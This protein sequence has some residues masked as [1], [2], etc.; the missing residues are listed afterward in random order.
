MFGNI[1]N[2]LENEIAQIKENGLYKNERIIM[3]PQA[4]EIDVKNSAK[5][6]NFC[7]NNYLGLSSHPEVVQ[8]AKESFDQWGYGL[9]SVRF[10][11]GTQDIHKQLENKISNFLQMDDTILYTSCFDAN[12]GLFETLLTNED[13]IISDELNHASIIDGVRLCKANRYRYK[14]NNMADLEEQLKKAQSHRFR[15]IV[16]DGVFSMD[17]Y[18]ADLKSI[19]DLA[20]KYDAMVMVDDSHSVGFMGKKGRGTHEHCDVMGRVDIITGTLGKALGGASGG[21]TSA[22]KEI[23]D[24]LRQRSR[25]Y[26]FSNTVA[27]SIVSA[28]LKV[29]EILERSTELRDKLMENT[30]YFREEMTKHGFNILPG[31][32]PIVPVMLGDAKLAQEMSSRLLNHGVYAIG[33]FYPVVPKEKARIRL[34]ISAAHNRKDLDHAINA[35]LKVR[36]ELNI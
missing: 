27:P 8:A 13:A 9:S 15:L 34:Q 30:S 10:I 18:I 32:H 19:C 11:C 21:Y 1:K 29:F 17:G 25:P 36:D 2:H 26:L 24:L 31:T 3:G 28:S 35:F 12:G 33:F 5:V 7:A 22:R 23:V 16:T 4:A 6:L 14:N 20:D